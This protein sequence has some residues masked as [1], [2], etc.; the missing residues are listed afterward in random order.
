MLLDCHIIDDPDIEPAY[1]NEVHTGEMCNLCDASL[2]IA[3]L[4]LKVVALWLSTLLFLMCSAELLDR[5]LP[6]R[7]AGLASKA[8]CAM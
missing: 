3:P 5:A 1:T 4:S 6:R 2:G 7:A 8:V